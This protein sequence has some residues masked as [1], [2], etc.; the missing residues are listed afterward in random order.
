MNKFLLIFFLSISALLTSCGEDEVSKEIVI[1]L[2]EHKFSPDIINVTAG[3]KFKLVIDNQDQTAEEFE[4]HDLKR[5]KI[6]KGNTKSVV[7][8]GSLKPGEY[9]Y[10]GEF[11]EDEA[12]GKII[13]K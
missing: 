13:A 11:N 2:K 5:E 12:Q 10:F 6:I 7:F 4:S 3:E 9:K 8:V 1:V